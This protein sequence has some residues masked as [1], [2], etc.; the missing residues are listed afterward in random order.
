MSNASVHGSLLRRL[1][2]QQGLCICTV[3]EAVLGRR[4]RPCQ[5]WTSNSH[6]VHAD[7]FCRL[8]SLM[9][10]AD[11]L[12]AWASQLVPLNFLVAHHCQQ[13]EKQMC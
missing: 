5:K 3:N 1:K 2:L 8:P 13:Q 4:L 6:Q 7:E 11:G 10:L 9:K 12:F